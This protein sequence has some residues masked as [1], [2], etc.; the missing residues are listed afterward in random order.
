MD[1]VGSTHDEKAN[2]EQC[3]HPHLIQTGLYTSKRP[4][5]QN[6]WSDRGVCCS[7]CNNT[8]FQNNW[9]ANYPQHN[10]LSPH[11]FWS[12]DLK[13]AGVLEF[14][15]GDPPHLVLC[16]RACTKMFSLKCFILLPLLHNVGSAPSSI[17]STPSFAFPPETA[18]FLKSIP[19]EVVKQMT[20]GFFLQPCV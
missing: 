19:R 9:E 16:W 10:K 1:T 14:L 2:K 20:S 7:V 15:S 13:N 8:Y 18:F 6:V 12:R 3:S 4:T 5:V 17:R 11:E